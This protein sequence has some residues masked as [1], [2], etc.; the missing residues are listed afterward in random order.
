MAAGCLQLVTLYDRFAGAGDGTKPFPGE[1][2]SWYNACYY[3]EA[4]RPEVQHIPAC[5]DI[6]F[7]YTEDESIKPPRARGGVPAPSIGGLSLAPGS[8]IRKS[9]VLCFRESSWTRRSA[10]FRRLSL[11]EFSKNPRHEGKIAGLK[12]HQLSFPRPNSPAWIFPGT[13][14]NRVPFIPF[15]GNSSDCLSSPSLSGKR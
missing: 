3:R 13:V 9:V 2:T 5:A 1:F 14:F 10:R 7:D 11:V 6:P 8:R 4:A 15:G 12:V